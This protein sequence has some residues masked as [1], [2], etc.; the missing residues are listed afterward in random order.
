MAIEGNGVQIILDCVGGSYWDENLKSFSVDARWILYGLLGGPSLPDGESG[1]ELLG[2]ILR[3]RI[4]LIGTTLRTR[5]L[6]VST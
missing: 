1:R 3:K 4:T 5:S 2:K 6:E